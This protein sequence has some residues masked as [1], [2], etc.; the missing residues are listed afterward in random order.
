MSP[1]SP[2]PQLA[3]DGIENS[4]TRMPERRPAGIVMLVPRAEARASS[5]AAPSRNDSSS[6]SRLTTTN[7][8]CGKSKK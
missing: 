3:L 5:R 8:S 7:A 6:G 1:I 2:M 4:G